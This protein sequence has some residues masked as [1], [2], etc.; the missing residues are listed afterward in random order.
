M[1]KQGQANQADRQNPNLIKQKPPTVPTSNTRDTIITANKG[2]VAP[3]TI[4]AKAS[5]Q[6]YDESLLQA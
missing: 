2:V 1:A 6:I 3:K 4:P 5:A